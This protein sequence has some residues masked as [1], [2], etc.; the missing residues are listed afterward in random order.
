MNGASLVVRGSTATITQGSWDNTTPNSNPGPPVAGSVTR[1]GTGFHVHVA[2]GKVVVID[3][4]GTVNADGSLAGNGQ[5]GGI[6]LSQETGWVCSFSFTATR[7]PA[8]GS[9]GQ[10]M[11]VG[12]FYSPSRNISCQIL[13]DAVRCQSTTPPKF[14]TMSPNGTY[15]ICAGNNCLGDIGENTPVLAY[16]D[17]TVVGPF[18]CVSATSGITCTAA[19]TG[20]RIAR[21]G[22]TKVP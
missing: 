21:S 6:H 12:S 22:V 9:A 10:T 11:N 18:T 4:T 1:N 15:T 7:G 20:F 14:V 8:A 5:S 2:N 13:S 17:T 19:G 16:G 3:L